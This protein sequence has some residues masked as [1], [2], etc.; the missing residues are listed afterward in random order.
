[1]SQ[2]GTVMKPT[3][4]FELERLARIFIETSFH[5][6]E[7]PTYPLASGVLSKYYIDCKMALSY[8]EARKII[9]ELIYELLRGTPIEAVGGL[10]LG[11]Y[12]I[13][14]AVS[15]AFYA[16]G[17][18]VRAFVVRKEPKVHGLRKYV[19][20][21]VKS[22]DRVLV[23]DDVITTGDSTVQAIRRCEEN[24]LKVIRAIALIDRQ[25]F[26]GAQ[27]IRSCGVDFASLL[28]RADLSDLRS[29]IR[30]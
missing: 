22:S 17:E 10:A 13:A 15:D 27:N 29:R 12:P 16:H 18:T 9:G 4:S 23:V 14:L 7:E 11:A 8:A 1:M 28:T 5:S 30:K 25:E 6:S 20:G 24:N 26:D 2:N 3:A 21:D 19:E